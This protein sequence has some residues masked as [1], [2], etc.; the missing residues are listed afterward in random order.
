MVSRVAADGRI[1]EANAS[2][3]HMLGR[4]EARLA[5]FDIGQMFH[6][7]DRAALRDEMYRS[8]LDGGG[9]TF[10]TG[11][12]RPST[13]RGRRRLGIA[14]RLDLHREGHPC[15]T[16]SSCSCRTSPPRRLGRARLQHIAYHDNLTDLANRNY[17]TEQLTRA[18]DDRAGGIVIAASG[19]CSSISIGSSWSTIALATVPGMPVD[20]ARPAD[21]GVSAAP[22][23]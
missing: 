12:A 8:I 21:A 23:I 17:F 13:A 20:R 9:T 6:P 18:I 16:A 4:A 7:E 1:V 10:A 11:A 2:L 22:R 3:A 14:Q 19:C 5:G 15:P